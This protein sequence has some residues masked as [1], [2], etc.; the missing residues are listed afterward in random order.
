MMAGQNLVP[1]VSGC[2][3]LSVSYCYFKVMMRL[4]AGYHGEGSAKVG[5]GGNK[6]FIGL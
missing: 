5:N 3:N 6:A 1:D 2:R 4:N